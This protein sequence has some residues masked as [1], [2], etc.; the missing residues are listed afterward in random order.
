MNKLSKVT[1]PHK[2]KYSTV[3]GELN[4]VRAEKISK[5][6]IQTGA[7]WLIRNRT[8]QSNTNKGE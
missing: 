2:T 3:K 5:F 7:F 8:K 4:K 1:L 6:T